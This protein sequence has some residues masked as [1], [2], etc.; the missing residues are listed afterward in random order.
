[1][2]EVTDDIVASDIGSSVSCRRQ[3]SQVDDLK[4]ESAPPEGV[5]P[6]RS[7]LWA[8][9]VDGDLPVTVGILTLLQ[10]FQRGG[11]VDDELFG[12]FGGLI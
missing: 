6:L 1:L 3:R 12:E 5:G 4:S 10:I 9:I 11:H 2:E 8:V 7:N